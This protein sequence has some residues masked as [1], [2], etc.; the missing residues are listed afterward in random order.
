MRG[1]SLIELMIVV[2]VLA[3]LL[4]FGMPALS[5]W[6]VD[7]RI[8][9][10][11]ESLQNGLRLAQSSA[12]QRNRIGVFTLTEATPSWQA[13]PSAN[14]INWYVRT[15]PLA[16]SDEAGSTRASDFYIE[17][18]AVSSQ[19]GISVSD[20]PAQLCFSPL[21]VQTTASGS[22]GSLDVSCSVRNP[23]TYKVSSGVPGSRSMNVLVY[24]GGRVRMCDPSKP[25]S[26]ET[27]YGC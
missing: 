27:P 8:R 9:S 11:A 18:N 15:L 16:G 22:Y 25:L 12:L 21:G 23:A 17:G 6:A 10:V 3:L 1:F 7:A 14:G 13:T 4:A 5:T 24:P 26:S 20:G 19:S 2:A